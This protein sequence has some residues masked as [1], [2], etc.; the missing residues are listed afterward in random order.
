MN[1][2]WAQNYGVIYENHRIG[3]SELRKE[4][5]SFLT[6]MP[7][8]EKFIKRDGT[9]I[10]VRN[11]VGVIGSNG[12]EIE[13][14]PKIWKRKG[15]SEELNLEESRKNFF[16]LFC[17]A[18]FEP[19]FFEPY[20]RLL[21]AKTTNGLK[22]FI[23]MLFSYALY[24]R[25]R[26]G[27]YRNYVKEQVTSRYLKGKLLIKKYAGRA[28]KSLFDV[29]T[30]SFQ[31]NNK[32][33]QI[34]EYGLEQFVKVSRDDRL[35]ERMFQMSS[36]LKSE[37]VKGVKHNDLNIQFNRINDR[38]EIPYNYA[39]TL[40]ENKTIGVAGKKKEMMFLYDMNRIYEQFLYNFIKRNK[41]Y[42]FETKNVKVHYQ[43]PRR[44]LVID[45]ISSRTFYT[46]IP[47]I[48][49]ELNDL[50]LIV[51]AKNKTN[52]QQSVKDIEQRDLYQ[53]LS[54][55]H[56]YDSDSILFYPS[57]EKQHEPIHGPY[58]FHRGSNYNLWLST[59]NLD[60]SN[61]DW[62]DTMKDHLKTDFGKVLNHLLEG[63]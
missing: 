44:N 22:D 29:S 47:D 63:K 2:T 49:V 53:M 10:R 28:N 59:L 55:S 20:V 32:L 8:S 25:L 60:F 48:K 16:N 51:D 7:G 34:F 31:G 56:S 62:I 11:Y 57:S 41:E 6:K 61:E 19:P 37:S 33:N 14:L 13:V 5:N 9:D 3:N 35:R 12:Y 4:L 15:R 18:L 39:R 1:N 27:I 42:I 30:H 46:T 26:R 23:I 36:V 21:D 17:Y 45:P 38:F 43:Q 50:T 58:R 40:L 24:D 52:E 54:Y